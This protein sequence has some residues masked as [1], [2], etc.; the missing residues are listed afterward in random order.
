[1]Q[2]N[3]KKEIR[4]EIKTLRRAANQVHRDRL[5][6]ERF[7]KKEIIGHERAIAAI[8]RASLRAGRGC[9]KAQQKIAKRILILEGRLS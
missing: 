7:A 2:L 5:A 3:M 1:M 6:S 8:Q 4:A 9:D